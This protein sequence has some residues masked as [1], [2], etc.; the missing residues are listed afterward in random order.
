[1][2]IEHLVVTTEWEKKKKLKQ[3]I[4]WRHMSIGVKLSKPV[5]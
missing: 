5:V 1:M 4:I 3:K 2:V